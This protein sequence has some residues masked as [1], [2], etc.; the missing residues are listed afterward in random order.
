MSSFI[1]REEQR[2]RLEQ[3]LAAALRN[4]ESPED[5]SLVGVALG[6]VLARRQVEDPA[7]FSAVLPYAMDAYSAELVGPLVPRFL[8]VHRHLVLAGASLEN[9]YDFRQC[10][11]YGVAFEDGRFK[12]MALQ[13]PGFTYFVVLE[14]EGNTNGPGNPSLGYTVHI[15]IATTQPNSYDVAQP[16]FEELFFLSDLDGEC[17]SDVS[18]GTPGYF[19]YKDSRDRGYVCTARPRSTGDGYI[20]EHLSQGP[21]FAYLSTI[22]LDFSRRYGHV[23]QSC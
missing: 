17:P 13:S 23:V 1:S 19:R 22:L 11:R 4:Y 5:S 2:V 21:A 15:R 12:S 18:N 7:V 9:P 16:T 6:N 14:L 8:A 20:C 3:A 10:G